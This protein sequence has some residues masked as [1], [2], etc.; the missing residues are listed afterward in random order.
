MVTVGPT[1]TLNLVCGMSHL[2]NLIQLQKRNTNHTNIN[3]S[4]PNARIRLKRSG[5]GTL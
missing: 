4:I 1:P 3:A 2:I 5:T